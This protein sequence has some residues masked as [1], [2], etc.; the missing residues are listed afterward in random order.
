MA[1]VSHNAPKA[2]IRGYLGRMNRLLSLLLLLPS[3]AWAKGAPSSTF[4]ASAATPV[5]DQPGSSK[6]LGALRP[7]QSYPLLKTGGPGGQ[8]CKLQL[9]E[10]TGW[11][12]CSEGAAGGAVATPEAAPTPAAPQAP[13][14]EGGGDFAY[15]VFSLSW[16]PAFCEGKGAQAPTDQCGVGKHYGF[17]VHG[18]WP[19]NE[20]GYPE[21]CGLARAT[22]A[23]VTSMLDLMPSKTLVNH[24]WSKHGTCS[25][26]G[27]DAYFAH[28]R[29][30]YAAI[31]IPA[32]LQQPSTAVEATLDQIQQMFI[33]ANPGLTRDMMSVQ[34]KKTVSEV[35][36]C[37]DKQLKLRDC[38]SD[39]RDAC[40]GRPVFPPLR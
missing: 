10:G 13:A 28:I 20:K 2:A 33:E 29:K 9:P 26:L 14:A 31:H 12:R 35:R 16:S 32:K 18:L 23:Q 40:K 25:G 15:Y 27:P 36:F 4:Q 24:E 34:C 19:Q 30:A 6:A 11:V 22:D 8:W 39:V 17:V 3:L 38:G 1:A 21:D 37:L 7:G 5:V